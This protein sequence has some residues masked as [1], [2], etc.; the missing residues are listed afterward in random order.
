RSR[1]WCSTGCCERPSA[2]HQLDGWLR[3]AARSLRD[4]RRRRS[5]LAVWTL[6][7]LWPSRAFRG[8]GIRCRCHRERRYRLLTAAALAHCI[9]PTYR[10]HPS[11][12]GHT[13]V[14]YVRLSRSEQT[15]LHDEV[16]FRKILL[17]PGV[18]LFENRILMS[19]AH[20]AA[21]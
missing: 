1:I 11:S 19:G 9:T 12:G 18:A 5:G 2:K 10:L 16:E 8:R 13:S 6:R 15:C 7:L 21:R 20:T 4:R 3:R 14:S 17:E